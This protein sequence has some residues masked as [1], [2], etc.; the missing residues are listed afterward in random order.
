MYTI[1]VDLPTDRQTLSTLTGR[2]NHSFAASPICEE[3]SS[4]MPIER[5]KVGMINDPTDSVAFGCFA[6]ILVE[7]QF[8]I[9]SFRIIV[10][11]P[12]DP[13]TLIITE[14]HDGG[15]ER[16]L[17]L[18]LVIVDVLNVCLARNEHWLI[19]NP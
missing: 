13:S 15:P 14:A 7:L 3:I 4:L 18:A 8:D 6:L 10:I 16:Q 2:S 5:M 1:I 11:V 19:V 17:Y 9:E 12:S